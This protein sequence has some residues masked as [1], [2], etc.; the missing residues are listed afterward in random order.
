[1]KSHPALLMAACVPVVLQLGL[2]GCIV[3]PGY[4]EGVYYEG[5]D[6]GP[7]FRDGTWADGRGW[8]GHDSADVGISIYPGR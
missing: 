5:S 8:Y 6:Q 4:D 7:W 3:R 2:S 1:M